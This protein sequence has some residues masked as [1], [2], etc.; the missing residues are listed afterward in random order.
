MTATLATAPATA[1]PQIPGEK[2]GAAEAG[3]G[4]GILDRYPEL[5]GLRAVAAFAVLVGHL[6]PRSTWVVD[7]FHFGRFGVDL[8]FILSGFLIVNILLQGR[9]GIERGRSLAGQLKNFYV[10]RVLRIFPLYFGILLV[11]GVLRY[12]TV[13]SQFWWHATYTSNYG[14]ALYGINFGNFEHFWSLCVEEQ[15]YLVIPLSVL[16]LPPR[17]LRWGF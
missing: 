13:P 6:Y 10:R 12:G 7:G 8:F 5:D 4:S 15:F 16:A 17:K 2:P 11:F 9:A 3:R 14:T 1:S